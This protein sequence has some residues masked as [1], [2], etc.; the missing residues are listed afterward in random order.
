[1]TL[2]YV[3][4]CRK[5][6]DSED[7]QVQSIE[8]QEKELNRE[9]EKKQLKIVKQFGEAKSAKKPGRPMF[10]EMM[11]MIKRGEADGIICWK[12]NRLARNPVDGGEIQW[13]LQQ[14]IIKSII[15]PSKEYLPSDNVLMM[16]VE[17]GMANQFII[18]LSKD[19]T[20]GM[21]TKVEKGWRPGK[22]PLGYMN[23]KF[24]E[25][26]KKTVPSDPERF[27]LTRKMWDLLLTGNYSVKRILEIATNDWGLKMRDGK[28]LGL[29]SLYRIFTNPFYYGEFMYNGELHQGK[30]E[31]MITRDEYDHAQAVLGNKGRPRPKTK[32]LPFS[33]LIRC[34]CGGTI[35]AEEKFKTI[36]STGQVKRYLYHH[37]SHNRR[38]VECHEGSATYEGLVEQMYSHFET[39]TIPPEFLHWAIEVLRNQNGIEEHDRNLILK[40]QQEAYNSCIKKVDNLINL[41]I[42]PENSTREMLSEEEFKKR[43]NALMTEKSHIEGEIRKIEARVNDWL[44]LSEKTFEFALYA[45]HW[46]DQGDFEKKGEI[47]RSLGQNFHLKDKKLTIVLQ[48]QYLTLK[49]GLENELLQKARLEPSI[50]CEDKIKNKLSQAV[51]SVWSG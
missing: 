25:K 44:E 19:V 28:S 42:L 12:I 46:F 37:C 3:M 27:P 21:N 32:R 16:A 14:G 29:S 35:V 47:L 34:E 39:I 7:R 4:Y 22:A 48:K 15:T 1:M 10:N 13:L 40:N 43:K 8:D 2:R 24:G 45:K 38:N 20:R 41:Y 33:G 50:Y 30:H 23:D 18:D 31:P 11:Q 6:T 49:N 51:F 36:K 9:I 5:S 17:L 26:G